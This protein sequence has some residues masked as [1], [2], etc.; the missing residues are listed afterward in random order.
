MTIAADR[1]TEDPGSNPAR[2]EGFL[3]KNRRVL[4]QLIVCV[5]YSEKKAIGLYLLKIC[6]LNLGRLNRPVWS[7]WFHRTDFSEKQPICF[8]QSSPSFKITEYF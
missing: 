6:T 2:A 7:P 3:E 4:V 5:I 8:L 1:G